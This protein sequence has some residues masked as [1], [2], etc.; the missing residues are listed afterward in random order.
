VGR[1]WRVGL[2]V[3][4][5]LWLLGK[6]ERDRVSESERV[7]RMLYR[8]GYIHVPSLSR[9]RGDGRVVH[10]LDVGGLEFEGSEGWASDEIRVESTNEGVVSFLFPPDWQ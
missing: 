5:S 3:A 8:P 1:A 7:G 2:V 10:D 4:G 6:R 9:S